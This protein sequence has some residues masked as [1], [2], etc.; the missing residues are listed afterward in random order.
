[1]S[2]DIFRIGT[3]AL[4]A[5]QTAL[6][7][8]GNNIANASSPGYT[9]QTVVFSPMSSTLIG[10]N[11]LG[12]GVQVADVRRVY[13]DFLTQ[14]AHAAT[15]AGGQAEARYLQMAQVDQLFADPTAGVSATID[16]FFR[17]VQDLSQRPADPAAR[18]ALLSSANLMATRLNDAG[19]RLQEFRVNTDQQLRAQIDVVNR[20]SSEIADLNQQIALAVGVG[21]SPNDLMDR[22]DAAVRR[23]NES[24]RAT[25]VPQGDG[26]LNVYIGTGQALVVG[27]E[28]S[29]LAMQADPVD[30]QNI[31]IGIAGA[32]PLQL[33]S[34]QHI[35]GGKIA[36]LMQFRLDD[37]PQVENELGRLATTLASQFN[38]QHRLG[39][40]RNGNPGL[41][42]FRPLVPSAFPA[43]TNSGAA[44]VSVAFADTAQLR[45]SDYQ[46]DYAAGNYTLTRL[47]D[48]QQWTSAVPS[49][50]Q[51]GLAITLAATPPANGDVFLI[52]AVRGG[53]RNLQVALSQT[54]EI[55]AALPIRASLPAANTGTLAVADLSVVGPTRDPAVA[56]PVLIRFSNATTYTYT[57]GAITSPPQTYTPGV[58]IQLN[59][60][61][62]ALQGT[63]QAN[64]E[65][66][67]DPNVG[68]IGDNRNAIKL[69]Q[70]QSGPLIDGGSL[71]SG[72]AAAIARVGADTQSAEQYG[73]AQAS[74]L[75]DSISAESSAAGVN[76]DEEAS[77]L[78]QFQQQYQA[79]AKVIATAQ[80]LFDE[81]LAIG[82]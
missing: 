23:L 72:V 14:Q 36:G 8:A 38:I 76:L 68:G 35:N 61:S 49:F 80:T 16:Q 13:N 57:I 47:S 39:D 28:A 71:S 34:A 66:R 65:V 40:D 43:T 26:T 25:V 78:I 15:A 6:R 21:R 37:L 3:T 79:A 33:L 17:A 9:R 12:Q 41:D 67:I 75:E 52:Q 2:S 77:R 56:T 32:G 31:R 30:P 7:T 50:T 1:M 81:I 18:Q 5:A 10:G 58:P 4:N 46:I 64:D 11:Y 55:A 51:D 24:I 22:R 44:T 60:W 48:G 59:G 29:K 19:E 70:L 53:A 42:F 74:I 69:A 20:T 27:G 82:R 54:T 45:A 62:L 63:A 73:R